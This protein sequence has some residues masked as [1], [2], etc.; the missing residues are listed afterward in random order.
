MFLCVPAR[1]ARICALYVPYS[2]TT[3]LMGELTARG[4]ANL[5]IPTEQERQRDHKD[6]RVPGLI[7]RVFSSGR[8]SWHLRYRADGTP[9]K[10][11]IGDYPTLSLAAARREAE[12]LRVEVRGGADP[13]RERVE[14]K[15]ADTLG[16]LIEWYLEEHCRKKL[17]PITARENERIL[18]SPDF[19]PLRKLA[20]MSVTDADVAKALDR[21]ERRGAMTM[22]NRAQSALS[23]VYT[24]AA[25]RRRAGV[26]SN[27]VRSLPRRHNERGGIRRHL[28][29]DDLRA[30]FGAVDSTP[31]VPPWA[32]VALWLI[33]LTGQ[34]PGEVLRARW[35]H[36]D[37]DHGIWEMPKGY[38]KR[39]RGQKEAPF[40]DVPLSPKAVEILR[41]LRGKD[42]AYLFPSRGGGGHKNTN[43]LNQ[44]VQ[45]GLLRSLNKTEQVVE[46]FTPHDLRRTASTHLHRLGTPR[47]VVE[48]TL[49]HVDSSVAGVYDRHAYMDERRAALDAWAEHLRKIV[50]VG[51]E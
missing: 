35:A 42:S 21:I 32:S 8:R 45:R 26:V 51:D 47:H 50:E 7:L 1:A 3:D 16:D 46:P 20:A 34:R 13:V 6:G 38:R 44:R 12:S 29:D 4:I 48:K 28:S 37:L 17:A 14:R 39:V 49:G 22:V 11:K 23:A 33:L 27:P 40:H 30:V 2:E 41:G 31:G 15:E 10:F 25:P 5:P 18:T 24:W 36:F 43:D 9:R 19:S